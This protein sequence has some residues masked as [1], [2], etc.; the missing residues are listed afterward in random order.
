MATLLVSELVAN[1]VLHAHTTIA[2]RVSRDV[3][4]GRVKVAVHDGTP[5]S[6]ARKHYSPTS[7]TGRGLL[8]VE[9]LA[10]DWGVTPSAAG[11]SVWFELGLEREAG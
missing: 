5:R 4:S 7:T 6:P 1:A 2:V 3:P 10:S 9:R 11:K 8:L